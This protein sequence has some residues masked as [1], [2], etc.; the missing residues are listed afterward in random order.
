MSPYDWWAGTDPASPYMTDLDLWK[1]HDASCS[2]S[3][4]M[5]DRGECLPETEHDAD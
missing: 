4:C 2:C 3:F 1:E 5:V